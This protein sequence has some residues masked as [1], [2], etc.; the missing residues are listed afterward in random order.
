MFQVVAME[1]VAS[2][3]PGE[4]HQNVRGLTGAEVDRILPAGIVRTRAAAV[5]ENLK[6]D[7]VKMQRMIEIGLQLPDFR[8][9]KLGTSVHAHRIEWL[10]VDQP[11][12]SGALIAE[13]E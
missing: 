6:V 12:M 7:Q 3:I 13:I 11:V 8:S 9:V 10:A 5:R 2:A 4:T 1:H